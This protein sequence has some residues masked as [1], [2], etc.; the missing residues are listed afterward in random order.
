MS[1]AIVLDEY[2]SPKKGKMINLKVERS[3]AVNLSAQEAKRKVNGW[4]LMEVSTM[5]G[6]EEPTLAIGQ[7]SVVWRV[8]IIFTAPH[9]GKVGEIG[10]IDVDVQTGEMYKMAVCKAEIEAEAK[11]LAKSLPPFQPIPVPPQYVVTQP[12]PTMTEPQGNPLEIL[13]QAEPSHR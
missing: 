11:R 1:L 2:T 4:L 13:G 3:F 9:V 10:R 6:A 8:P 12:M 7:Q 5:I